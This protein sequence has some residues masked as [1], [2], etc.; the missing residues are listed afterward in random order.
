M[1][2]TDLIRKGSMI[3]LMAMASFLSTGSNGAQR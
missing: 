3:V 1:G 2:S